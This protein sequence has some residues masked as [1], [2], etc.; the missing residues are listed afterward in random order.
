VKENFEKAYVLIKFEVDLET[1]VLDHLGHIN[2]VKKVE[3]TTGTGC[4]LVGINSYT[5]EGLYET[6]VSKIQK[7]P[8]IYST[9]TLIC[10]QTCVEEGVNYE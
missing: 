3:Y 5:A 7:I 2:G 9:M 1:Y 8:L 4:I 10:G 6:I